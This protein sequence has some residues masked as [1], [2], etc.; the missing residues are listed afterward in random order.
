MFQIRELS[1]RANVPAKTIR[2]YE[3]IGLLAPA[4]RSA[5]GYRLYDRQ[6]AERLSFIRSA[7]TLDFSLSEIARI[8]AVRD[9]HQPPCQHVMELIQTHMDEVEIRLRELQ[10]LKRDLTALYQAGQDLPEDVQMSSCVCQLIRVRVSG[11]AKGK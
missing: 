11:G 4:R 7:R 10:K 2:Y 3:A 9:R 5:N 8:L 6:D 1:D